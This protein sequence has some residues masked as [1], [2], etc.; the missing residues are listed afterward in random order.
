MN[1]KCIYRR[2]SNVEIL[3]DETQPKIERK[4]IYRQRRK[5]AHPKK[6]LQIED[7][8]GKRR[9]S[10][11]FSD[12]DEG[13]ELEVSFDFSGDEKPCGSNGD[14][15]TDYDGELS[16][17]PP[18]PAPPPPAKTESVPCRTHYRQK[19]DERKEPE[20]ESAACRTHDSLTS[21]LSCQR[22]TLLEHVL[23]REGGCTSGLLLKTSHSVIETHWTKSSSIDE[24]EEELE[25][26]FDSTGDENH[27]GSDWDKEEEEMEESFDFSGEEEPVVQMATE[28]TDDD[29]EIS[30]PLRS[31]PP[32]KRR[33][34]RSRDRISASPESQSPMK[35]R[36]EGGR[37]I[38]SILP[39]ALLIHILSFLPTK[40]IVR[41]GILSKRWLYLW[42]SV[43]NIS[44][45]NRYSGYSTGDKRVNKFITFVDKALVLSTS[46]N[47]RKFSLDFAYERRFA[48]N[49]NL[50]VRFAMQKNVE[51]LELNLYNQ[52]PE[53]NEYEDKKELEEGF[54]FNEDKKPHGSEGDEDEEEL[55]E[56][57]DLKEDEKPRDSDGDE[58]K[59]ELG[60]RF[61]FIGDE[62]PR[63]SDF[64]RLIITIF[65]FTCT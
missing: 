29:D 13:E 28:E 58:D 17:P 55:E 32:P 12:E 37:D 53:G 39:D 15:D 63:C 20:N 43:E 16:P 33:K 10:Y 47:I 34:K 21:S 24:D 18:P 11:D 40:D 2:N 52:C 27:S 5:A 48:P 45:K 8:M 38:I 44:F 26:S 19:N 35:R 61:D 57:F 31:P 64:N 25:E 1:T 7:F 41:T 42:A 54:D 56:S 9:C 49:V 22:W 59:E 3:R 50:W 46:S 6:A 4:C 30:T 23:Y 51:E 36:K 60:V 62:K 14:E 65:Y